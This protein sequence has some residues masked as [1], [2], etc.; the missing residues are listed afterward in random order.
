MSK[1]Y[2]IEENKEKI[3]E[4]FWCLDYGL[5]DPLP[6]WV[7]MP[8]LTWNQVVR[9]LSNL[10]NKQANNRIFNMRSPTFEEIDWSSVRI[11]SEREL[12]ELVDE[13][14]NTKNEIE[15][16]DDFVGVCTKR[17]YLFGSIYQEA[18]EDIR[19]GSL[20]PSR[21]IGDWKKEPLVD[22]DHVVEGIREEILEEY[23]L[24]D[25]A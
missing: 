16:C 8:F 6:S 17:Q 22:Y 9:V 15:D 4:D 7:R 18:A 1:K 14:G 5:S 11:H 2:L 19:S 13:G 20:E 12:D 10:G 3:T 21:L 24:D 25:V 23:G